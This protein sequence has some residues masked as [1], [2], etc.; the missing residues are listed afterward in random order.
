MDPILKYQSFYL[1]LEEVTNMLY[2]KLPLGSS[3]NWSQLK[4]VFLGAFA[5]NRLGQAPATRLNG[6]IKEERE[7]LKSYFTHFSIELIDCKTI[8]NEKARNA[9][10][11]GLLML[12]SLWRDIRK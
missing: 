2:N 4:E 11:S 8:S 9:L 12:K 10:W 7:S 6:M 3:R 1:T 5:R